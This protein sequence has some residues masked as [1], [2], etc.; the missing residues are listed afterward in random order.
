[1]GARARG[2]GE[3]RGVGA[4]GS[5]AGSAASSLQLGTRAS[6]GP[7]VHSA[8]PWGREWAARP[9]GGVSLGSVVGFRRRS[10]VSAGGRRL[11]LDPA[12]LLAKPAAAHARANLN[13]SVTR[14]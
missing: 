13:I 11:P 9:R 10:L 4:W 3:L 5:R 1:M 7:A 14:S 2:P 12:D 8:G 6:G